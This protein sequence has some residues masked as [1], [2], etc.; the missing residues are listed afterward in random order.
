MQRTTS[1]RPWKVL[2]G[3]SATTFAGGSTI[4]G[5]TA[6]ARAPVSLLRAS[7]QEGSWRSCARG[8]VCGDGLVLPRRVLVIGRL[9][10]CVIMVVHGDEEHHTV[11]VVAIGDP[12]VG[13][14]R[15]QADQRPGPAD[16][17]HDL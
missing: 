5:A 17:L 4:S 16:E 11:V 12:P 14:V 9:R 15:Q 8:R 6:I 13:R 2:P 1:Y 7:R 3:E 10:D